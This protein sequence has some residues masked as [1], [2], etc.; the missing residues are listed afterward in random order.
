MEGRRSVEDAVAAFLSALGQDS[1][2]NA[3]LN[4]T[5]ERVAEAWLEDLI[6][7]YSMSAEQILSERCAAETKAAVVVRDLR[8]V[9]VCPHHL[10]PAWGVAHVAYLPG[11]DCVGFGALSQLVDCFGRRL[12]LQEEVASNIADALVDELGAQAAICTLDLAHACMVVRGDRQAQARAIV[13]AEAGEVP[14]SLRAAF[15][16]GTR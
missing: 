1:K 11:D 13:T 2:T 7:G 12:A 8:A 5:P 6:V 4:G 3:E 14:D 10:L 9:V 15:I 16:A